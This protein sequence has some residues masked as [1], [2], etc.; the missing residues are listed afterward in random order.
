MDYTQSEYLVPIFD[1]GVLHLELNTAV[2][3]LALFLIVTFVLN[4]ML[5][6][7]VLRTLDAR[8]AL[9]NGVRED[10]AKKQDEIA[11]LTREYETRM[12][13]IRHELDRF[14]QDARRQASRDAEA[15][16]G[17][18]RDDSEKRLAKSMGELDAEINRLRGEVL[19]SAGALAQHITTRILE[20]R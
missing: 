11:Q 15:I 1:Y 12:D 6:R 8:A 10:N 16:L 19:G 14:R 7:P 17:R 18:A 13:E 4:R 2:F 20:R 3:I 5:F 9:V